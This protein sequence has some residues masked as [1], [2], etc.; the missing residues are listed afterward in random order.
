M[1]RYDLTT[2]GEAEWVILT[3]PEGPFWIWREGPDHFV[4]EGAPWCPIPTVITIRGTPGPFD[5][6]APKIVTVGAPFEYLIGPRRMMT[7]ILSLTVEA[8]P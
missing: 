3:T 1:D 2:L 7:R 6:L 5:T 4:G 8:V